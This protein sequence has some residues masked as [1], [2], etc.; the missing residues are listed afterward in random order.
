[1]NVIPSGASRA[2]ARR[3]ATLEEAARTL[4]LIARMLMGAG[5]GISVAEWGGVLGELPR[6]E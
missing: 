1:M 6:V 4:P 3:R 2:A 5:I